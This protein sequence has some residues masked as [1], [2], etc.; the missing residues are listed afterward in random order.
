MWECCEDVSPASSL[1]A[2]EAEEEA[3]GEEVE[4]EG[5]G[6]EGEQHIGSLYES[7]LAVGILPTRHRCA[8]KQS[9]NRWVVL[10]SPEGLC[11]IG[12]FRFVVKKIFVQSAT[13]SMKF[14]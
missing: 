11:G 2:E 8:A 1:A 9:Q 3:G 12:H 6:E 5:A 10:R 13:L 7:R 14:F 4:E